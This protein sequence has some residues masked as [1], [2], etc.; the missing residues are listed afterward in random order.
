[1]NIKNFRDISGYC[2]QEGQWIK[3]NMIF[4]GA[5]LNHISVDEIKYMEEELG[6]RYILDYRDEKEAML[7]KDVQFPHAKYERIS[8]LKTQDNQQKGFDF[9]E[10][11]SHELTLENIQ[12][13]MQY[14]QEGYKT[15]AF[16]NPAYHRL[17]ELL[18]RNDGAVYFHCS[19]GKDR[20]GVSAFL[21]MIA[22]GISEEDCIREYML[23]N[24][25]L[26]MFVEDFYQQHH[27]PQEYR[28]Y[29]DPLLYV[30]QEN[31]M[32]T[33]QSIKERYSNYDEFL[34]KEYYI[35]K[36]KRKRLKALYCE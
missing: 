30:D 10:M 11:L 1:M 19:A 23:S 26:Q 5:T 8:A 7:E 14:I 33:I 16:D 25:Y 28:K 3:R 12:F 32:L 17:F 29:S 9:G 31:I 13:L 6:I 20:T 4:R 35:D 21:I 2:N 24:K 27:V 22:L 15:M 18:L 34:E 36:E